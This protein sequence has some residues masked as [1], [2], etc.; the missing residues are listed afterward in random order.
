MESSIVLTEKQLGA[1]GYGTAYVGI[2]SS[3]NKRYAVK[4]FKESASQDSPDVQQEFRL[5]SV[6]DHPN[7][8]KVHNYGEKTWNIPAEG[9]ERHA[10]YTVAD[11]Y[12]HGELFDMIVDA[13]G[14]DEPMCRFFFKQFMEGLDYLHTT[15]GLAHRDLKGEN[16]L[17]S[18]G[19]IKIIDFG[20]TNDVNEPT[21][22][23]AIAG[24]EGY[25]PPEY[26]NK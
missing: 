17:M 22:A 21:P 10:L 26:L 5:A 14:F 15:V 18:A 20:L 13:E 25:Q 4:I 2:D 16:V 1:G 12:K 23:G 3:D 11:L 19:A 8:L 6:I 24:T 7:C 9:S